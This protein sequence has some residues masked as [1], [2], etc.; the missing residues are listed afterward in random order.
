VGD[1]VDG[2]QGFLFGVAIAAMLIGLRRG[3]L[4]GPYNPGR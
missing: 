2:G 3:G 4:R 1:W